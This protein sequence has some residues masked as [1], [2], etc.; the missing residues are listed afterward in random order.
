MEILGYVI[1]GIGVIV[2]M[3]LFYLGYRLFKFKRRVGSHLKGY[4]ENKEIN[5]KIKL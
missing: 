4:V 1:L 2:I 5:L 3:C